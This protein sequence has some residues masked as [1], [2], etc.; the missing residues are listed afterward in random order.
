MSALGSDV[1][2]CLFYEFKLGTNAREAARK[3]CTAFG[4]DAASERSVEEYFK[5]FE[6]ENGLVKDAP[7]VDIRCAPITTTEKDPTTLACDEEATACHKEDAGDPSLPLDMN[8]AEEPQ[9]SRES[10]QQLLQGTGGKSSSDAP[11][12]KEGGTE[13]LA[14]IEE[15][16]V[17]QEPGLPCGSSGTRLSQESSGVVTSEELNIKTEN[18]AEDVQSKNAA[19]EEMRIKWL[20][21]NGG[22]EVDPFK[23]QPE[24]STN[25][26]HMGFMPKQLLSGAPMTHLPIMERIKELC[27]IVEKANQGQQQQQP[28]LGRCKE[29][30]AKQ[31]RKTKYFC[32][33]CHKYLCLEHVQVLCK[34]CIE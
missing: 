2:L 28:K 31:N 25:L 15:V 6:Q 29:C 4:D 1:R 33:K 12:R 20:L 21:E 13:D 24:Y 34:D 18:F 26:Q 16:N 17:K 23:S 5:K 10:K 14:P 27:Q 32:K 3:I 19:S 9:S 22:Y 7:S 8:V 30:T 11:A